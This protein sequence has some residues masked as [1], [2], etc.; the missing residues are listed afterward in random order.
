[1]MDDDLF[2]RDIGRIE[3]I[4]K[5]LIDEHGI[6][7]VDA[8]LVPLIGQ[9]NWDTWQRVQNLAQRLSRRSTRPLSREAHARGFRKARD[10]RTRKHH[11]KARRRPHSHQT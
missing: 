11:S 1:M 4:L 6:D 8:A 9:F 5:K 10:K 3:P 2:D 7:A